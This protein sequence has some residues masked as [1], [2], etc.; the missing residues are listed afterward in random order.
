MRILLRRALDLARACE[1][2]AKKIVTELNKDMDIR[3]SAHTFV[4]DDTRLSSVRDRLQSI[5]SRT[6]ARIDEAIELYRAH[7]IIRAEIGAGNSTLVSTLM[8]ESERFLIPVEKMLT[9]LLDTNTLMGRECPNDVDEVAARLTGIQQ[10]LRTQTVGAINDE[11]RVER[12]SD[13]DKE[14]IN[15]RLAEIQQRLLDNKEQKAKANLEVSLEL[16]DHVVAVLRRHK[17]IRA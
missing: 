8:A 5:S 6:K 7:S 10:R 16:P 11:V 14:S 15:D 3:L 13:A 17:I 2:E 4:D 1:R 9:S 12:L